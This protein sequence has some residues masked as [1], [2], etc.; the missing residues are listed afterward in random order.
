[1]SSNL[2]SLQTISRQL[3]STQNKLAT[4]KKVNSAIDNPSNYY[5]A[6]SLKNQATDLNALLDNMTQGIQTIKTATSSL[7]SGPALLEQAATVAAQAL[8]SNYQISGPDTPDTPNPPSV[9]IAATVSTEAELIA[10]INNTS[11]DDGVIVITND[12]VMSKN[13]GITLN[14][15]QKL[16]GQ[17]YVD[18]KGGTAKLTF[19]FLGNTSSGYG[20]TLAQ[21]SE[22]SDLSIDYTVANVPSNT[23]HGVFN[24]GYTG[25]R[26]SNLDISFNVVQGNMSYVGAIRNVGNGE[27][28]LNGTININADGPNDRTCGISEIYGQ[29]AQQP[30]IFQQA[31]SVLNI[32]TTGNNTRGISGGINTFEGIINIKAAG[33][34]IYEADNIYKGD[35]NIIAPTGLQNGKNVFE[36]TAKL[37]IKSP[38]P[39]GSSDVICKI[40]AII[41]R[42]TSATA[43]GVFQAIVDN[44]NGASV[45]NGN[46]NFPRISD[47]PTDFESTWIT[48][49][50]PAAMLS[51]LSLAAE[52][53][54]TAAAQESSNTYLSAGRLY[55]SILEQYNNLI[56]DSSYK[57]INLLS[58]NNLKVNFNEDRSSTLDINGKDMSASALG[59]CLADWQTM[60]DISQSLSE[61][62]NAVNSIRS[63][64]TELGNH[65]SIISTRQEF[66]E[67]LVNLLTEGYDKLTLA[68]MNEESANMLALQTRQQLAVNAFSLSS[69]TAQNILKLF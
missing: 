3:S 64:N 2:L 45:G 61:I 9:K 26:L 21:D 57:G 4:G 31:G 17:N 10:A 42:E 55:N 1:M 5:S 38:T 53:Y 49:A 51:I 22:L 8:E 32:T 41:G 47:F 24:N 37:M 23:F 59:L 56:S 20:I 68:D 36:S 7:Q 62:A 11:A 39:F 33:N 15:G 67:S 66:T 60:A 18:G 34:G 48:K 35:V 29:T 19:D 13:T 46:P 27:I 54:T 50:E 44:S 58:G 6:V 25:I 12:I 69:Q 40:G 63:F 52:T 43:T 28:T 30:K 16:V 14:D 65:F